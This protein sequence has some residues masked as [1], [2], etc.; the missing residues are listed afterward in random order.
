MIKS[1]SFIVFT[2]FFHFNE[3]NILRQP[4]SKKCW[5]GLTHFWVKYGQTQTLGKKNGTQMAGF[6]HI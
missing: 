3:L 4:H 2:Q 1:I 6:V 5:I